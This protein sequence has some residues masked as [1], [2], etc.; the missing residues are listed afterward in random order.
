MAKW[1]RLSSAWPCVASIAPRYAPIPPPPPLTMNRAGWRPCPRGINKVDRVRQALSLTL[2]AP[3]GAPLT[4][5]S[6]PHLWL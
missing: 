1:V 3:I 5:G 6:A 4:R 2:T